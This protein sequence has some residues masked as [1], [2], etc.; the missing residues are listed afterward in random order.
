MAVAHV[1]APAKPST[2][3]TKTAVSTVDKIQVCMWITPYPR[4]NNA[5]S[6]GSYRK[7][8]F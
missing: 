3:A 5:D 8:L 7:D 2:T 4:P 6:P 1:P